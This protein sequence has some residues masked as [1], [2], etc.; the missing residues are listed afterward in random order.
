[1]DSE[2][3]PGYV[4]EIGWETFIPEDGE[5]ADPPDYVCEKES[6]Y[7]DCPVKDIGIAIR[8]HRDYC[9]GSDNTALRRSPQLS[10]SSV[11]QELSASDIRFIGKENTRQLQDGRLKA[12]ILLSTLHYTV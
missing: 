11:L 8:G 12:A 5:A 1:M 7:Q 6:E 2:T 3:V 4:A 9:I 10:R